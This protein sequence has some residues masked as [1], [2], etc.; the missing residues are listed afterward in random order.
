MPG[1]GGWHRTGGGWRGP[2]RTGKGRRRTEP[3][4]AFPRIPCELRNR[5][6]EG[7]WQ[8]RYAE[9]AEERG[10]LGTAGL[11]DAGAGVMGVRSG[12]LAFVILD[13]VWGR[14][15]LFSEGSQDRGPSGGEETVRAM[16]KLKWEGF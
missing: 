15:V 13:G 11:V 9:G 16:G 6:V 2:L 14:V 4:P 3:T 7:V 12:E 1:V 10:L 5:V 8:V